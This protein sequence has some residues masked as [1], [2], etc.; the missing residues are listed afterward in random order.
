[1]F[2]LICWEHDAG[3]PQTG[4]NGSVFSLGKGAEARES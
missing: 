1:V 3:A 2:S 4:P